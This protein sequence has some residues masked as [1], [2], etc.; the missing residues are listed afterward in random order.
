MN[1]K[2]YFRK[3]KLSK[4]QNRFKNNKK[5]AKELVTIILLS[6]FSLTYFYLDPSI[7]GLGALDSGILFEQSN[8]VILEQNITSLK[9]SGYAGGNGDAKVYL[10]NYLVMNISLAENQEK[11]SETLFTIQPTSKITYF[12]DICIETCNNIISSSLLKIEINGTLKLAIDK[13]TYTLAETTIQNTIE[14]NEQLTQVKAEINKPVEWKLNTKNKT[15]ELPLESANI[16][17]EKVIENNSEGGIGT[18]GSYKEA[19][20]LNN[21]FSIASDKKKLE[22]DEFNETKLEI[23]Y[24]TKAPYTIETTILPKALAENITDNNIL[25]KNITI[26]SDSELHYENVLS[27]TDLPDIQKE[28][29]KLL[30][31]AY[32]NLT[33]KTYEVDVTS[34]INYNVTYSDLNNNG[35]IDRLYWNTPHLSEDNYSVEIS[36]T[37]LTIQ[38]YPTV[39]GNWTVLFNTTGTANLTITAYNGTTWSL[40]PQVPIPSTDLLFLEIKCGD[41]LQ[42]YQWT[43]NSVFIPDYSC[44]YTSSEISKVLTTGKHTLQF[45]FGNIIKYGYNLA[46]VTNGTDLN[47]TNAVYFNTTFNV[48]GF[49]QL[50]DSAAFGFGSFGRNFSFRG[51][52]TSKIFDANTTANW[53]NFSWGEL[54][55]FGQELVSNPVSG[56]E[57]IE[58]SSAL[59]GFN[60]TGL[61]L[62]MHFNNLSGDESYSSTNGSVK[63]Y[64][65]NSNTGNATNNSVSTYSSNEGKFNG[66]FNFSSQQFISIPHTNLLGL[67]SD[68][69]TLTVSTWIKSSGNISGSYILSKPRSA[70][71]AYA[72]L[73]TS[74]GLIQFRL[75]HPIDSTR[76]VNTKSIVNDSQWHHIVGTYDNITTGEFDIYVDGVKETQG[77]AD[78]NISDDGV[79]ALLIGTHNLPA[80]DLE[81]YWNGSIDEVS[82]W[83]RSLSAQEVQDLYKRGHSNLSLQVRSCDD[84][85]C[86]GES[87]MGPDNTSS[88]YFTNATFNTLNTSITGNNRY[89]QYQALFERD[90][91]NSNFTP[92]LYNFTVG[93]EPSPTINLVFPLNNSLNN[94]T[95]LNL[96]YNVSA[97][98]GTLANCTLFLSAVNNTALINNQTDTSI[99]ANINQTFNLTFVRGEYKWL[100]RCT[101]TNNLRANSTQFNF[102]YEFV[103]G[104]DEPVT[105]LPKEEKGVSSSQSGF[106]E[107][108]SVSSISLLASG[109]LYKYNQ[110]APGITTINI[111][112]T[113][114]SLESINL[115]VS[116]LINNPS[117]KIEEL[118]NIDN[119][120][121][122]P[123]VYKYINVETDNLLDSGLNKVEFNF[124]LSKSSVNNKEVFLYLYRGNWVKL[125]TEKVKEEGNFVY[126]R[127]ISPH[128]SLFAIRVYNPS[129][130][131]IIKEKPKEAINYFK[132]DMVNFT[133]YN[134]II[135]G[136]LSLLCISLFVLIIIFSKKSKIF[137]KIIYHLILILTIFIITGVLIANNLE[138]L[139][140]EF[141]EKEIMLFSF[142]TIAILLAFVYISIFFIKRLRK[143][144]K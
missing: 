25:T 143:I 120:N 65:G 91:N 128:L 126:Y 29:I 117:I 43:D 2:K 57:F 86:S 47:N 123:N 39:G 112:D 135:F 61:V 90:L 42:N 16:I 85:S 40:E 50:N 138:N 79:N 113:A 105:E 87:F 131:E 27:Y 10:D 60:M 9:I 132:E 80:P 17:V 56:S 78:F 109:N 4:F 81:S 125:N 127:G 93:Y 70:F 36:L 142:A 100:V 108:S 144:I 38:S 6:L 116:V 63:D 13:F 59:R 31:Y 73:G 22:I 55:P 133:L 26:K 115:D 64:S 54:V 122:L 76:G 51:N 88:S 98:S 12:N 68:N 102:S 121:K 77:V 33:N 62:L 111:L 8:S 94:A 52:Y 106:T 118:S 49:I 84:S 96:S 21:T 58:T 75:G 1:R 23:T 104:I 3:W 119:I 136:L 30:H 53:S 5:L 45:T 114:L 110:L 140:L 19:A 35:L 97:N 11:S 46:S 107:S 69:R 71:S 66:A 101:N 139:K 82:I 41:N 95:A 103:A 18:V 28:Q 37:I 20:K 32:D 141:T 34:D 48:S 14:F 130:A 72:L 99:T 137:R 44:N 7:T 92:E 129:L 24:Y 15:I 134:Y 67:R 83:N 74:I 89:F 124:K